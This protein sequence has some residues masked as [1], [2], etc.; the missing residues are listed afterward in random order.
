MEH[1]V[2]RDDCDVSN[3]VIRDALHA[4]SDMKDSDVRDSDVKDSDVKDSDVI[5]CENCGAEVL[6]AKSLCDDDASLL[7]PQNLLKNLKET[8]D[9]VV[10]LSL[11]E[12]N[13]S[14]SLYLIPDNE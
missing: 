2:L 9:D 5:Q 3:G 7:L 4:V 14:D 12:K 6:D 11:L 1:D 13:Q 8:D 10:Q